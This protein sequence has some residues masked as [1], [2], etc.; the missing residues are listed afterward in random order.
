MEILGLFVI[1]WLIYGGATILFSLIAAIGQDKPKAG[2][3]E[4][5]KERYDRLVGSSGGNTGQRWGQH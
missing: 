2:P 4:T 3:V 5:R 1:G